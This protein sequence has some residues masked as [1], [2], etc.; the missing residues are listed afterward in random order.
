MEVNMNVGNQPQIIQASQTQGEQA[1]VYQENPKD[2]S[3]I[4]GQI[5]DIR[6][7]EVTVK[8]TDGVEVTG[9]I[10]NASG[11]R[12]G[13]T[14][15]FKVSF[16]DNQ[17]SL[18]NLNL[19]GEALNEKILG[20]ILKSYGMKPSQENMKMLALLLENQLPATEN[21]LKLINQAFKLLGA[22]SAKTV[23]FLENQIRPNTKNADILQ[24]F[25]E[26]KTVLSSQLGGLLDSILEIGDDSLKKQVVD[27][28]LL[29]NTSNSEKTDLTTPNIKTGEAS[30]P[31][32][33]DNN[34]PL[35]ESV[36]SA[37]YGLNNESEMDTVK[38]TLIKAY[39]KHEAIINEM[40]ETTGKEILTLKENL[41]ALSENQELSLD[42][43]E[44]AIKELTK[45][46]STEALKLIN[47]LFP[48]DTDIRQKITNSL[49][50]SDN[51]RIK[52]AIMRKFLINPEH[53]T[54]DEFDSLIKELSECFES[55]SKK[56]LESGQLSKVMAEIQEVKDS[57]LFLSHMKNNTF[58]QIPL[59]INEN[60]ATGELYVFKDKKRKNKAGTDLSALIALDTANLGRFEAYIVKQGNRV[61]FQFRL[62]ND[63]CEKLI[64]ENI[65]SLNEALN[66]HSLIISGITYKKITES[67]SLLCKEP[68]DD[69]ENDKPLEL[70]RIIFDKRM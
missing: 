48:E 9:K 58:I 21:N 12:I 61:N 55:I 23:F 4:K 20:D 36:K 15:S 30:L 64:K 54:K 46:D 8:Q 34:L 1:R 25:A 7:K 37:I 51:V 26:H 28:L 57:L 33:E 53:L 39:P 44:K 68:V 6:G 43:L 69:S 47:E 5:T 11:L 66:A 2:G 13:D 60:K 45:L 17:L 3:V 50:L 29:R 10:D 18:I 40:F 19:N 16:T 65:Q 31:V 24:G 14:Q 52:D 35:P 49:G 62:N 38:E 42:S 32:P 70:G 56:H 27:E 41:I 63:E 59:M 67:F 22:D